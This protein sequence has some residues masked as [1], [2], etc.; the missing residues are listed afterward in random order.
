MRVAEAIGF[1]QPTA[2]AIGHALQL[3][4]IREHHIHGTIE[5]DDQHRFAD[6]PDI[7]GFHGAHDRPQGESLTAS[8]GN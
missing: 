3:L 1:S 5:L 4:M 2:W 6:C 8:E 7:E